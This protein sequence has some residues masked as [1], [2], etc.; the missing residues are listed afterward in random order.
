MIRFVFLCLSCAALLGMAGCA[1]VPCNEVGGYQHAQSD[2]ELKVPAGLDRPAVD[3]AFTIPKVAKNE[4]T[5][6]TKSG[7]CLSTPPDVVKKGGSS[8]AA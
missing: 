7:V 4:A 1:A 5:Q 3:P 2:G 8:D 6:P